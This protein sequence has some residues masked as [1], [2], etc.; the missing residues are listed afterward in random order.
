[1]VRLDDH[2][3]TT[4]GDEAVEGCEAQGGHAGP[5]PSLMTPPHPQSPA[6]SI[7]ELA[8]AP[9]QRALSS[10]ALPPAPGLSGDDSDWQDERGE[11]RETQHGWRDDQGDDDNDAVSGS[12]SSSAGSEIP[13]GFGDVMTFEP[14]RERPSQ[15]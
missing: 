5:H 7:V 1:M 11:G 15:V 4:L 10:A 9:E 14:R 2:I 8:A 13:G 12:G 3:M 6:T